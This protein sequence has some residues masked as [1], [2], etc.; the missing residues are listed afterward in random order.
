MKLCLWVTILFLSSVQAF[1]LPQTHR[2]QST[3]ST[4]L[5]LQDG[6]F[7][8]DSHDDDEDDELVTREM[9]QR[10]LL[11]DPKVKRKRNK[12][13]HTSYKPLD[14][15]D[16]L[17]FAVRKITPDPYTHPEVKKRNQKKAKKTTTRC[18]DLNLCIIRISGD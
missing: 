15:R 5:G 12:N 14:N 4:T 9:L 6:W 3:T 11:A 16:H 8:P 1:V 18:K 10:D 2:I 13:G 17:P 7:V